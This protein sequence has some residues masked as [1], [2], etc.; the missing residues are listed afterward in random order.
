MGGGTIPCAVHD[1]FIMVA[2]ISRNGPKGLKFLGKVMSLTVSSF[3]SALLVDADNLP[4]SNPEGT[5]RKAACQHSA[6]SYR[7]KIP[8]AASTAARLCTSS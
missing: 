6:D 1:M 8:A 4:L 2:A 3:A 5:A 7:F